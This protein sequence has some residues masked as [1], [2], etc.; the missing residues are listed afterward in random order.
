M[1]GWRATDRETDRDNREGTAGS[2]GCSVLERR[3][4]NLSY[5]SVEHHTHT[6]DYTDAHNQVNHIHDTR[7]YRHMLCFSYFLL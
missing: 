6:H 5:P 2:D 3:V 1:I 4:C 7:M